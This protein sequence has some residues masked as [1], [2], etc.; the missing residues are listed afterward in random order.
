MTQDERW[1]TR[2]NEVICFIEK[3]H[4]NPSK[5]TGEEQ[6]MYTVVKNTAANR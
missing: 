1:H 3:R 2:Y 4:R 5:Y 6:N